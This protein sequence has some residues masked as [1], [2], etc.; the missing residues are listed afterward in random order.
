VDPTGGTKLY[1]LPARARY[2]AGGA[3]IDTTPPTVPT[4][5]TAT[6]ISSTEIDLSWTASTDDVG[7]TGYVIY[8]NGKQIGT[9]MDTS[10]Q[11]TGLKASTSYTYRVAAYDE[12]GNISA[13]SVAVT[14]TTQPVPS[15]KFTMGD[16]VRT[17]EKATVR[18]TPSSSGVVLN[19][20]PK[21]AQGGV[22][23]GPWYWN[24]RWWW[25]IDFDNGV[26]GWVAQGKLKKVVP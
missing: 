26:D 1:T 16:R 2:D 25:E 22:V 15:T 17:L 10:Y 18:S 6:V 13:K 21:A 7:V 11:S 23:G 12:A 24:Q 5:V 9:T 8:R 14:R 19:T 4:G 20:Q 3:P